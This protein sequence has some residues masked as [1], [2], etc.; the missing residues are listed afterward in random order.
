M[1]Y[2]IKV[3]NTQRDERGKEHQKIITY[4]TDATN[5]GEAGY[6]VINLIGT[7]QNEVEDVC[8]MKTLRELVN[9]KYSEDNKLFIVKIAEDVMQQDGT[10]KTIK[11]TLAAFANDSQSLQKIMEDYIKQGLENMRLT[12]ISETRWIYVD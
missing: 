3:N 5:F 12:T 10:M 2:K 4:L 1:F 8:L 11:Y 9:T 7:V 6:K